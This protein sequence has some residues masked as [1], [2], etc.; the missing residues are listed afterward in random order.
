MYLIKRLEGSR[1]LLS[2]KHHGFVDT[3]TIASILV[4]LLMK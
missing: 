3:H 1:A 4:M 2:V